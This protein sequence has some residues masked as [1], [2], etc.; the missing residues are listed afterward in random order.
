MIAPA[1]PVT[2]G[3]DTHGQT[4]HAAVL[5][6]VGRRLNDREFSTT[7]VGY[8]RMLAWLRDHGELQRVGVEGT[9]TYGAAPSRYLRGEGVAVLEVDRPDRKARRARGKFDAL[10]AYAAARAALSGTV[11]VTPKSRDGHVEAIRALRVAR[12]SAVKARTQAINQLKALL[13]T[14][15]AEL[16]EQLRDLNTTTQI[17]AC[18]RLRPIAE[19]SDPEQATKTAL[20]RLAR[21]HQHLCNEIADADRELKALVTTAAPRLLELTGV[22]VEVAGQLLVT[23]GDNPARLRSEAAFAHLCGVAPIPASSGRTHRHRLNRGG[24]RESQPRPLHHRA[25][26]TALRRPHPNLRPTTHP[27]RPLQT[28]RHPLPQTLRRPRGLSPSHNLS[29]HRTTSQNGLTIHRWH[30]PGP[31]WRGGRDLLSAGAELVRAG[32]LDR[33]A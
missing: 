30:V 8:R 14:G 12:A 24:D 3:V 1:G 4:H 7:P 33:G 29:Q 25:R 9:G 16:R 2:G 31:S 18:A 28:R 19:L 13:V 17:A 5:D 32:V 22:G 6:Q 11:T 15:P 21:R 20:R 27:T 26:P 10:D 23:A